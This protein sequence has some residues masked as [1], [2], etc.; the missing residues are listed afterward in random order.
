MKNQGVLSCFLLLLFFIACDKSEEEFTI[1]L[2]VE[3][4]V[5][6]LIKGKYNAMELPHFTKAD[7]PQLLEYR[8][9]RQKISNF[10]T[11]WISSYQTNESTLGMYVL[12]TVESIRAVAVESE[13][14]IGRFPSQN[15]IVETS[16]QPFEMVPDEESLDVVAT[17]YLNWWLNN[18]NTDF[19]QFKAID[20]LLE[21]GLKWH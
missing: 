13:L 9:S 18:K 20:P 1:D 4:Y 16:L 21:T 17:A 19:E 10:P 14:L 12:W 15:P 11:N 5:D 6:L 3:K 8:N 2:T 7:I